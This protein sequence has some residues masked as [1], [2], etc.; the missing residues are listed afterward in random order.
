MKIIIWSK[1]LF[2]FVISSMYT[3]KYDIGISSIEHLYSDTSLKRLLVD[4]SLVFTDPKKMNDYWRKKSTEIFNYTNTV[5]QMIPDVQKRKL[6]KDSIN[7]F[8][9]DLYTVVMIKSLHKMKKTEENIFLTTYNIAFSKFVSV[10]QRLAL[11]NSY[12]SNIQS[13]PIGKKTLSA[14]KVYVSNNTN[15]I[16]MPKWMSSNLQTPSGIRVTF[17]DIFKTAQY[18][19]YLIIYGASWCSPCRY[20]NLLLKK[21]V[22]RIDTS[23]VKIIGLSIDENVTQWKNAINQD[24]CP[25]DNFLLI[26]GQNASIYKNYVPLGIPYNLLIDSKGVIIENHSEINIV[27]NAL[28]ASIYKKPL[29]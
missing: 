1:V 16:E 7:L 5:A 2:L 13:S 27:L 12:P 9:Q 4:S 11:F 22:P 26:G 17:N 20:E 14:I 29:I 18:D 10:N 28:P 8:N 23:K 19:Y 25:W 6:F 15:K 21:L 24:K 3:N